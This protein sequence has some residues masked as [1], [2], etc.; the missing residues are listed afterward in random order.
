MADSKA[1]YST[2]DCLAPAAIEAKT[3]APCINKD[4]PTNTKA[5]MI[6]MFAGAFIAFSGLFFTVF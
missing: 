3:E 1:E 4:K 2:P 6:T 5:Y